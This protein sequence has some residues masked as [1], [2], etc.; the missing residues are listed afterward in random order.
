[1]PITH[2]IRQ[3]E[4]V[5]QL[6]DRYGLFAETIWNHAKN[7]DLKKKRKDMNI[8]MPGDVLFIPDKEPKVVDIK[9]GSTHKFRRKGIPAKLSLQL[10]EVSQPR[11]NQ[12]FRLVLDGHEELTG[13]TDANGVLEVAVPADAQKGELTIGPDHFKLLIQLGHLDPIEELSGVQKRLNNLGYNCGAADGK[14]NAATRNAII[15]FQLRFDLDETGEPD[16]A[17]VA[18]IRKLHDEAGQIPKDEE[19]A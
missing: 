15:A 14:M 5:I 19:S 3:G 7:A 2:T 9:V 6:A 16:E 18:K 13:T 4:S 1:M 8:L 12:S 11:A 17:T 10:F